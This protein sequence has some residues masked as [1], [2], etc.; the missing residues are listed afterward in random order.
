MTGRRIKSTMLLAGVVVDALILTAWTQN[1]FAIALVDDE[2]GGSVIPVAGDVA[3]GG[4]AALGLA[5]LALV[6][7]LSI[8]GPVFR[9]ILGV[10]Q[11]L[12]GATVVLSSAVAIADPITVSEAA[13]T[14]VTGVSGSSS[15]AALVASSSLTPW[16]WIA[17]VVGA[18]AVALGLGIIVT[19][20]RWPGGSRRY[21]SV[22]AARAGA[23]PT[24]ADAPREAPDGAGEP[25]AIADWDSLSDGTDPTSR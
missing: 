11:T 25:D 18:C 10:L 7:A 3:A 1:W 15:I 9:I 20:R 6:G 2:L 8:A 19:S 4:L 14:E 13:V 17:I 16:P 24:S 23:D 12:I 21:Q 5:G 22:A